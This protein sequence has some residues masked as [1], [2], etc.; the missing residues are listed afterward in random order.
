MKRRFATLSLAL[1]LLPVQVSAQAPEEL[2][3]AVLLDQVPAGMPA[4]PRG[5]V[6][7]TMPPI[8]C[9]TMSKAGHCA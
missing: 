7:P 2:N 3:I 1:G 5:P 4:V 9:A 6:S 8:D